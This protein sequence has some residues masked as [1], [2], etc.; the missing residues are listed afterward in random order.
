MEQFKENYQN[1]NERMNPQLE[2]MLK[3]MQSDLANN[4][5]FPKTDANG[6]PINFVELI[7]YKRFLDV[8][9][10]VKMYTNLQN[11]TGGGLQE[12]SS[13]LMQGVKFIQQVEA[14]HKQELENLAVDLVVEEMEIPD[15]AFQFQCKLVPVG[16][17][18]QDGFQKDAE[19][20]NEEEINQ[21]FKDISKEVEIPADELFEDEKHKRRFINML[22]QGSSKKGHYMFEL[23]RRKVNEYNPNLAETYGKV[24]SINDL[25]YW[26][27][28]DESIKQ[29]ASSSSSM[30]GKE[31]IE[32]GEDGDT[33]I[34]T[35]AICFPVSLHEIIKGVMEVFGSQGLPDDPQQATLVIDSVDSLSNETMDLRLGV[36][37]WEKIYGAYPDFIL[38]EGNRYLQSY[39]FA[40]YCA[41]PTDEFFRVSR[42]ILSDDPKGAKYFAKM[43]DEIQNDLQ[44]EDYQKNIDDINLDDLL[45]YAMGGR[46]GKWKQSKTM[47]FPTKEEA[48]KRLAFLENYDSLRNIKMKKLE[49]GYII[50]FEHLVIDD[51]YGKDT[52]QYRIRKLK[53]NQNRGF[54]GYKLPDDFK[55][56]GGVEKGYNVF[57][58]TDNVYA[59]DE[60]FKTKK[61]ANEFIK[62][63]RN[64]FSRQGYYRDNQ[65]NKIAIEDI[66]LLA[67]PT[68]FS[69][70]RKFNGGGEIQI[71]DEVEFSVPY[72][73]N[74]LFYKG[75]IIEL[76]GRYAVVEYQSDN[77][78]ILR[79]NLDL[80]KL[81]KAKFN[82]GGG[83]NSNYGK[84]GDDNSN[85]V[86][87]DI[88][89]LDAFEFR[90]YENFS[91]SLS[92]AQALQ[93]LINDVEGDYSQLSEELSKIAEEQMPMD[94][95]NNGGMIDLFQDYENIPPQVEQILDRYA[96]EFGGDGSEMDYKDTANMLKEI[97]AVGY[98]F[99]YYL[100]NEPY[101]LRPIGVKI[102]E[103]QGY[104]DFDDSDKFEGGGE[105][106][107]DVYN[108]DDKM[109]LINLGQIYEYAI[110]LDK[111]ID[112]NTDLEE[113]VKMKLTRIE[114]NIADVKHSLEGWEKY[115]SGGE[116][117]KKQL[118]HIAKYSKDLIEMISNGSKLMSW[119]EGK[120]SVSAQSIDDIYHHLD[121]KMG[122]RAVDLENE[123]GDKYGKGRQ[124]NKETSNKTKQVNKYV[125]KGYVYDGGEIWKE[126]FDNI[127]EAYELAYQIQNG[128]TDDGT[129]RLITIYDEKGKKVATI[130][131]DKYFNEL[132]EHKLFKKILLGADTKKE[133]QVENEKLKG[134]KFN[135]QIRISDG[136]A[137]GIFEKTFDSI[138]EV[139]DK[140]H[141]YYEE[142][143]Y[144]RINDESL[145]YWED[146][147][148]EIELSRNYIKGK[149]GW[150]F[151]KEN[152]YWIAK[153]DYDN[154][155][156]VRIVNGKPTSDSSITK[157]A[158]KQIMELE[159]Q[160]K[161]SEKPKHNKSLSDMK[162][163]WDGLSDNYKERENIVF[164]IGYSGGQLREVVPYKFNDFNKSFQIQI[165]DAYF[166]QTEEQKQKIINKNRK[167]HEELVKNYPKLRNLYGKKFVDGGEESEDEY[168]RG[169][170][171]MK[172][173]KVLK[174][175]ARGGYSL[176]DFFPLLEYYDQVVSYKKVGKLELQQ[177]VGKNGVENEFE[178]KTEA[179]RDYWFDV[180]SKEQETYFTVK[181]KKKYVKF[182]LDNLGNYSEEAEDNDLKTLSEKLDY[183]V[184]DLD[185]D[186]R[187]NTNREDFIY[188]LDLKDKF[189]DGGEVQGW[190]KEALL[191]LQLVEDDN[192]LQ[193]THTNE[194]SFSVEGDSAE[195]RVFETYAIA[196]NTAIEQVR[197]DLEENPDY[198]NQD[199]LM[200]WVDVDDTIE[201][202]LEEYYRS[203]A[204][205]IAFEDD[206]TYNNRLIAEMVANGLM[207]EEEATSEDADDI[208]EDNVDNLVD[209][210]VEENMEGDKGV[211]WY[212]S[213]F[214]QDDFRDLV[215]D[216]N[217]IDISG[218]SEDAVD[219]DGVAHFLSSYDGEEIELDNDVVAYRT[220]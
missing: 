120:L 113:W 66:D 134:Y 104:E 167:E 132:T 172:R 156:I 72:F 144:A 204:D 220:N 26:L 85:L 202:I 81:K 207:T 27:L 139:M 12:L 57:N 29:M 51:D 186:L 99:D 173:E 6:N 41:L 118:L 56:G 166:G 24:M 175:R 211:E 154:N 178:F 149:Y 19:E 209:L 148:Y 10:K 83:V 133:R 195:Y 8:I 87:F 141:I 183:F 200:N 181:N 110:E 137:T 74:E 73:E 117:A 65:M 33:I 21:A 102:T 124:V 96:D 63:F 155:H 89:N 42:L 196:Y 3:S 23:V 35:E 171:P 140:A 153:D 185:Y 55:K 70:F 198:F 199:W 48:E 115:S 46:T 105:A 189:V 64:R 11:V 112:E 161:Y 190:M 150:S 191:N 210:Y 163:I 100:N 193:I 79:T 44:Q 119:Q 14:P 93:V 130:S 80:S 135:L 106:E 31:E 95:Y 146:K 9:E 47:I 136:G 82:G 32:E 1:Q 170:R 201:N 2:N 125:V 212:I 208:A 39:L 126:T 121:Y 152:G 92:K 122:N 67:I 101:G 88:D 61:L 217:L 188:Y 151:I 58:Y 52:T 145:D 20:P 91:K 90:Q 107:F 103:L 45:G 69:P 97:E 116:I 157:G 180:L 60:V 18:N 143:Y 147:Y 165:M 216:N 197:E 76:K 78:R 7:A 205:D 128:W 4:P 75:K 160:K 77:D 131:D 179:D 111:I 176:D 123:S 17:I 174:V 38:E 219:T 59:T 62:E 177:I 206:S 13:M 50:F 16:S 53:L 203:Y 184:D 218:A 159:A 164:L 138:F 109:A 129:Y 40:R 187:L 86:N 36:P 84:F 28:D 213:N 49:N 71:G 142:D 108:W 158:L 30:A 169:G 5:A 98:T 114:Q 34:K 43:V 182:V 194:D 22:I 162:K 68:D 127:D 37:C 25:I 168:S 215:I 54:E 15:G 94:N 192:S 214:G